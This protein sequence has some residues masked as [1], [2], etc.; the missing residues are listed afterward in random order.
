VQGVSLSS[1]EFSQ[2]VIGLDF[3]CSLDNVALHIG[4]QVGK[5]IGKPASFAVFAKCSLERIIIGAGVIGGTTFSPGRVG[6]QGLALTDAM[7]PR[8]L[9]VMHMD[10][11]LIRV[12]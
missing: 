8:E 9:S 5:V 3:T 1:H 12:P 6:C 10:S 4:R 2:P 11:L 7:D